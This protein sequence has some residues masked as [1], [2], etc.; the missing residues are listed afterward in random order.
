MFLRR[1]LR[2]RLT[3][4]NYWTLMIEDTDDDD[5][6]SDTGTDTYATR[7]LSVRSQTLFL[8]RA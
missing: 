6:D 1:E 2:N 7:R 3:P 4:D 5:K 8:A